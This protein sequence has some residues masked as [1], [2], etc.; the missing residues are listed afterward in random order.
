MM[1]GLAGEMG[2]MGEM[3][4][5]VGIGPG[6]LGRLVVVVASGPRQRRLP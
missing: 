5:V 4:V 2:E 3:G 6:L 1:V